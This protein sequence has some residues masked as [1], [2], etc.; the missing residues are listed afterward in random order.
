[1]ST[2][3]IKR[4]IRKLPYDKPFVSRDLL[5]FG[6]RSLVD[7]VTH[8]LVKAGSIV[9]LAR[10]VFCKV[11]D[12][13]PFPKISEIAEAKAKAF[14][15]TIVIHGKNALAILNIRKVARDEAVFAV[16]GRTSSFKS[17]HGIIKFITAVPAQVQAGN[18]KAALYIRAMTTLGKDGYT[19]DDIRNGRAQ[20]E[21]QEYRDTVKKNYPRYMPG[22][23][24]DLIVHRGYNS[25]R[26][27]KNTDCNTSGDFI[28]IDGTKVNWE[29]IEWMNRL[30]QKD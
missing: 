15:K 11:E 19:I 29:V 8:T 5:V 22:W 20:F 10:G 1:M 30:Y 16:S 12:G 17:V 13:D 14:G 23:L 6:K 4:Y 18:E 2:D 27:T 25:P 3:D 24:S 9:R 26:R 21:T 28:E 7:F